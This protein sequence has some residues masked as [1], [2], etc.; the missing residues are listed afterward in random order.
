M[1]AVVAAIVGGGERGKGGG[2][3]G[4]GKRGREGGKRRE[5]EAG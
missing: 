1:A 4:K 3:R 2:G 5:R